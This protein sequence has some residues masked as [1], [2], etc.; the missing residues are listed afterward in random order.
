MAA[1]EEVVALKFLFAPMI[2]AGTRNVSVLLQTTVRFFYEPRNLHHS[3]SSTY[4]LVKYHFRLPAQVEYFG[5]VV[6]VIIIIIIIV[7][8]ITFF[9]IILIILVLTD[10]FFIFLLTV[11]IVYFF[12]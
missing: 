4:P 2:R 11:I 8:V 10:R 1:E 5:T 3:G 7:V 6:I 12:W 9:V